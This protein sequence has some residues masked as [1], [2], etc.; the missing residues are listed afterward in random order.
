MN[1]PT[2]TIELALVSGKRELYVKEIFS[3]ALELVGY[4]LDGSFG[5]ALQSACARALFV[6]PE[7]LDVITEI[8]SEALLDLS[9]SNIPNTPEAEISLLAIGIA[10]L[11]CFLQENW[12]GPD[13]QL[14][15]SDLFFSFASEKSAECDIPSFINQLALSELDW[16]GEPGYH[17]DKNAVHLRLSQVIIH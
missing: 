2:R 3:D 17:R 4:I 15:P 6:R 9:G 10:S 1:F 12:T 11:H 16:A 7:S 14:E 5:K 8:G 13:L